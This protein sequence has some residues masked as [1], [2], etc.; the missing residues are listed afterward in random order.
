MVFKIKFNDLH[1]A[2]KIDCDEIGKLNSLK[3]EAKVIK[4][5][6]PV[7]KMLLAKKEN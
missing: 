6:P 5:L 3:Y 7:N 4:Y 2:V 1:T